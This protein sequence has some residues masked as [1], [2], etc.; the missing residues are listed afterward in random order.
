MPRYLVISSEREVPEFE[1]TRDEFTAWVQEHGFKLGD[2]AS[3]EK[4]PAMWAQLT[5]EPLLA[6]F[7]NPR[8][9]GEAIRYE[10]WK[11]FDFLSR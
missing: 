1:G 3:Y 2:P 11:V 9:E 10:D 8:M 5:G 6:G 4:P 7:T